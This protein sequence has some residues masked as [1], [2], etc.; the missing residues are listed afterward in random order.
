M[1]RIWIY[2]D[3]LSIEYRIGVTDFL[4]CISLDK[5]YHYWSSFEVNKVL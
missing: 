2:Y 1:D 5:E 3:R 4:D